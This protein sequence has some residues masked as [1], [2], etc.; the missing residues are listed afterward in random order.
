MTSSQQLNMWCFTYVGVLLFQLIA[1]IRTPAD[2]KMRLI[3]LS[4]LFLFLFLFFCIFFTA[5]I[6]KHTHFHIHKM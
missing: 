4:C 3:F 1:K 5:F 2:L 6:F